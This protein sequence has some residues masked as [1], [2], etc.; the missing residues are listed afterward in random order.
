[1]VSLAYSFLPD[2][3]SLFITTLDRL[4][5]GVIHLS[6]DQF[7]RLNHKKS[8]VCFASIPHYLYV[9]VCML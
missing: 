1:M 2:F 7:E 8:L 3:V 5:A 9:I 4:S 6:V